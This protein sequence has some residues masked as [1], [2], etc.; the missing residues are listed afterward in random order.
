MKPAGWHLGALAG[1]SSQFATLSRSLAHLVARR[2]QGSLARVCLANWAAQI[3]TKPAAKWA[4]VG[5]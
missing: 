3:S 5:V 1:L 4:P 2:P